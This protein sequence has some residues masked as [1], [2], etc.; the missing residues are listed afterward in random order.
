MAFESFNLLVQVNGGKLRGCI[1]EIIRGFSSWIKEL[2][3]H[4][5]LEGV[6]ACNRKETSWR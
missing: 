6:E 1:W 5:L 3:W 4:C 2:N